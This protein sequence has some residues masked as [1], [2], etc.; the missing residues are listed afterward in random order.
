MTHV[1][2]LRH[3][4][5]S[6]ALIAIVFLSAGASSL[7]AGSSDVTDVYI[8]KSQAFLQFGT[9]DPVIENGGYGIFS[10]VDAAQFG[11]VLSASFAA[12]GR[13][14]V[15]LSPD[16][17]GNF[18]AVGKFDTPAAR[19]SAFP[20]GPYTFNI[21]TATSPT[22]F[23]PTINVSQ[24]YPNLPKL[25]NTNWYS[26]VIQYD[27]RNDFNF[28][29]NS[30][31]G[32]QSGGARPSLLLFQI[33]DIFNTTVFERSFNAPAT[34][35]TLPANT[36]IPDNLY[37]GRI[38]FFNTDTSLAEFTRLTSFSLMET[39]FLITPIDGP[40]QIVSPLDF[41][42]N[43]GELFIYVIEATNAPGTYTVTN[44][45]A[46]VVYDSDFGIIGGFPAAGDYKLLMNATNSIGTGSATLTLH[47]NPAA[48][49]TIVSSTSGVGRV[50]KPFT[51]QVL[52][53][54]ATVGARLSARGLPAGLSADAVSGR[55]T[56]SPQA[57]GTSTVNLTVTDGNLVANGIL[58]LTF[59][60]D[61]AFP[62]IKSPTT[63]TLPRG[64]SFSYQINAQPDSEKT[65]APTYKI[66]GTLPTGLRFEAK[67]G[68]IS[69]V[70]TGAAQQ[71]DD[72]GEKKRLS[73][74]ALVGN[75]QLFATNSRGTSS[76]PLEF[77][78]PPTGAVNISTR[79]PVGTGENVL[80]GGFIV[81][82][83]APKK[84]V[85]RGMGPSLPVGGTMPDPMLELHAADGSLL[86]SNDN[87][88]SDH[89]QDIRD[90]TVPPNDDREAAIV[91]AF[92]PGN[93]TAIVKGKDGGS[94]I[95]LVELYDLGTASL[96]TTSTAQL[97]QISTRGK[98]LGG[99]NVMIGGFIISV[100]S[101][102]VIARA[103]GPELTKAGLAGA[104]QD[105]TLQL[106]DGNGASIAFND[107]WQS[108]QKD[109]IIATTVPPTDDR[110]SAIVATL[111]PGNYTAIVR[112]KNG[113]SGV[114]LVEVYVLQ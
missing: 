21:Q 90:T 100:N 107:D 99:D 27:S 1:P 71:L 61:P 86:A 30:F 113:A 18:A 41:T 79:M 55:I 85:V 7:Y 103:I 53:N 8:G 80:I 84:L 44:L 12:P 38:G 60:N 63:T 33:A 114:A 20:D 88:K 75:V 101:S 15:N 5:R 67:T 51:F 91:G 40:P 54:G 6:A 57:E 83:N 4:A 22:T 94:G 13:S 52:A 92:P 24:R 74:G 105:T 110:E 50:G 2:L 14:F 11:S 42:A 82:G 72:G 3:G 106:Y 95:G 98:V 78:T 23:A 56:G 31:S 62:A 10:E 35:Q 48:S 65:D 112:G 39:E 81:T 28:N 73:G 66:I 46:G 108:D 59:E 93:Y 26:V 104:L 29:W 32:F 9:G 34:S 58:T 87:W 68:T 76:I 97:A 43:A 102:K 64:Q 45:P 96:D 25:L 17:A 16:S 47:V 111:N 69:G 37:I 70:Y 19:D 77:F 89:E 49:L 36:L 109:A